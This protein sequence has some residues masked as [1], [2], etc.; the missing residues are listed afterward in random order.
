MT[1]KKGVVGRRLEKLAI[2]G[3]FSINFLTNMDQKGWGG[4]RWVGRL[5][6]PSPYVRH[7]VGHSVVS[8]LIAP[9]KEPEMT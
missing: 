3:D 2:F 5:S 4:G 7:Y 9:D 1:L 8:A 6:A